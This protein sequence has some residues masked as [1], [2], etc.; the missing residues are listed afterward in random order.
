MRRVARSKAPTSDLDRFRRY[1]TDGPP[2]AHYFAV[3][4]GLQTYDWP[5]LL[6]S[7]DRGLPYRVMEHLRE[8]AGVADS[9]IFDWIQIAPRTADR[10]KQQGRFGPDE[11][12]RLLRVA[13]ILGRAIELFE[14][15]RDEAMIWLT[16]GQ[17]AFGGGVPIE[18]SR[19]ELGA[20]EVENLIGRLE[21]GVFS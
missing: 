18:I 21:H 13:R 10:R 19:T 17:P 15:D 4:L 20:R 11:S 5:S 16:T 12:D 6:R 2:G 9:V 8:N 1:M 3:L 14:G 7:V